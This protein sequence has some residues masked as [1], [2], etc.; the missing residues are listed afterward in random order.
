MAKGGSVGKGSQI[1]PLVRNWLPSPQSASS[2]LTTKVPSGF[3]AASGSHFLVEDVGEVSE[4][5]GDFGS[6]QM[7]RI[8]DAC[9]DIDIWT[10]DD[11]MS[12][13]LVGESHLDEDLDPLNVVQDGSKNDEGG[14]EMKVRGSMRLGRREGR[15]SMNTMMLERRRTKSNKGLEGKMIDYDWAVADAWQYIKDVEKS[16]MD[17]GYLVLN[18][19]VSSL[20]LGGCLV[21]R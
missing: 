17:N 5:Q 21:C 13:A 2:V 8:D 1:F 20:K 19:T 4:D 11:H 16:W 15:S 14:D 12:F 10:G 18:A 9:D 3:G 6:Y 7:D